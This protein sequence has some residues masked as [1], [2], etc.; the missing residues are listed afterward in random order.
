MRH[1]YHVEPQRNND[2]TP[3]H[4]TSIVSFPI[5]LPSSTILTE[6][7][8]AVQQ[9]E[10]IVWAQTA[11]SDNAV[12][13]TCLYR[14]EELPAMRGWLRRNYNDKLKAVS[15]LLFSGHG[16]SQAP[17]EEIG[18]SRYREMQ[19]ATTP[20]DLGESIAYCQADSNDALSTNDDC[21]GGT[22]PIR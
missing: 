17:Y 7:L 1:G 19:S 20:I 14:I 22:C 15:F 11:W 16:F 10:W 3:N 13:C 12:S 5:E 21:L 8:T 6:H 18:E 2:G 9:L 4:S